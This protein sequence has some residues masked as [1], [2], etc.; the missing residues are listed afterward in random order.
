MEKISSKRTYNLMGDINVENMRK[1]YEWYWARITEDA[2][3]WL[4]FIITSGGGLNSHGIG[5]FDLLTSIQKSKIQ[6]TAL[7]DASSIAVLIFMAGEHRV[8]SPRTSFLL[9]E[10]GRSFDKDQRYSTSDVRKAL[11]YMETFEKM[12][13]K[14]IAER[15]DGKITGE[16][17][18][19]MMRKETIVNAEQALEFGFAHEISS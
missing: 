19:E 5:F 15:S 8:I 3:G 14:T 9:H 4:S 10:T 17:V 18:L 1:L 13:S 11:E 6:T 2:E 7:G 16:K 12:Y